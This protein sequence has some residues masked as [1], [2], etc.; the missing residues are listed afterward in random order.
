MSECTVTHM[1]KRSSV[2]STAEAR[3][4]TV[5]DAAITEFSRKGYLGTPTSAVAEAAKI[6]T[7]YVFKLF[8]AK[9]TLFVAALEHCFTL[10]EQALAQG[11]DAAPSQSPGD[12][13]YA[14]GGTYAELISDKRLLMLQVHAQA[15]TD[16]PEIRDAVRRGLQR[17]TMFVKQRSGAADADVQRMMAVGQLCHLIVATGVEPG[18]GPW[19]DILL[20]G[21][22]HPEP[23]S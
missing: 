23:R 19:A 17:T 20:E 21:I 22:R 4:E 16:I 12:V 8:P 6:S 13:L 5:I 1:A 2:L 10:I 15:A 11:A 9:E 14:M 7:A 18:D 3:R